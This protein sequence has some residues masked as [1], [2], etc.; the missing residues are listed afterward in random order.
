M[1]A[2]FE[3]NIYIFLN[4]ANIDFYTYLLTKYQFCPIKYCLDWEGLSL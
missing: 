4:A 2:S 3:A 1:L